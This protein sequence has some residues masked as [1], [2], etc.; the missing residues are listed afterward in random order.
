MERQQAAQCCS[1]MT[2]FNSDVETLKRHWMHRCSL[3]YEKQ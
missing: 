3:F 2:L 1:P